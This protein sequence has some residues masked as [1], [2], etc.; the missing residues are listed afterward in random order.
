M[1]Q[2]HI[3]QGDY[4]HQVDADEGAASDVEPLQLGN[5]PF[6]VQLFAGVEPR[7][8]DAQVSQC[9]QAHEGADCRGADGVGDAHPQTGQAGTEGRPVGDGT[10]SSTPCAHRNDRYN[11]SVESVGLQMPLLS[12]L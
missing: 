2:C 8:A 4:G 6:E 5:F 1:G 7:H 9:R 11:L 10:L 3:A 12:H